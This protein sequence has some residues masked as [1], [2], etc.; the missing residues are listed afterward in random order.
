MKQITAADPACRTA[1]DHRVGLWRGEGAGSKNPLLLHNA[2]SLT[3]E[4]QANRPVR[5]KWINDLKDANGNYL[6]H[7]L[8]GGPNPALGQPA[9]R[10]NGPRYAS[11]H[12][13]GRHP[14][15]IPVLS[16]WSPMYTVRSA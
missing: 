6:P 9:R 10:D 14:A 2:P 16:R 15:P 4:A 5:I 13:I 8:P 7:L 3:I 1:Y 12:F 11:Q